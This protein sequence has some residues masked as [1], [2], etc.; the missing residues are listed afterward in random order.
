MSPG[1]VLVVGD[2][3]NDVV[4][5]PLSVVTRDSDT[6]SEVLLRPGGQGGNQAAWLAFLGAPVRFAGRAGSRDAVEHAR[7]LSTAGVEVHLV[8]DESVPTGTIVVVLGPRAERSMFTDRGAGRE[9]C[10]AD[11][12]VSLL[13]GASWLHL[14]G[15]TFFEARSRSA[16]R[17]L[18]AAAHRLGL[19]VSLDPSS[20]AWLE[21][22]GRDT[23]L[24]WSEGTDLL[25]PNLDEGRLLSGEE[26]PEA[27][28]DAL[29]A[30]F[31][32]VALK[33]GGDGALC[34]TATGDRMRVRAVD[35]P[36]LDS[37]GAGDAFAAGYLA[38]RLAGGT[39]ARC[40]TEAVAASGRAVGRLGAR[41]P[42]RCSAAGVTPDRCS[43]ASSG[44]ATPRGGP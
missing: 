13:D 17:S 22:V 15:Y 27:V 14:S 8:A 30:H 2:V 19:P 10:E 21:E 39:L 35:A 38:W 40:A 11:L 12:P 16:V 37:T 5:R 23:F 41:P 34:A 36:V 26:E 4:V 24:E 18:S 6:P 25:F 9:L 7:L 43:V 20:V 33:L 31:G 1:P 42:A 29:L 3:I 32:E 44:R 28:A